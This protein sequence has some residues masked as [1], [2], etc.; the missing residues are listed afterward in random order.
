[1]L[2]ISTGRSN[3]GN[4]DYI[5]EQFMNTS[6]GAG[7]TFWYCQSKTLVKVCNRLREV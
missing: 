6:A 7:R 3:F 4:V 1:M 5:N 2:D